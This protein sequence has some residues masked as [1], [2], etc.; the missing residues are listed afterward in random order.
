MDSGLG[1]IG[2][3]IIKQ[4]RRIAI[5]CLRRRSIIATGNLLALMAT[6]HI[7][8]SHFRAEEVGHF[9]FEN[10]WL[11]FLAEWGIFAIPPLLFLNSFLFRR[12]WMIVLSAVPSSILTF[13]ALLCLFLLGAIG[14]FDDTTSLIRQTRTPDGQIISLYDRWDSGGASPGDNQHCRYRIRRSQVFRGVLR[15][16]AKDEDVCRMTA[17]GG[18]FPQELQ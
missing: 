18:P 5:S 2:R 17:G 9:I 12:V 3:K 16:E 11:S 10:E 8:R 7:L 13:S 15:N 6:D 1:S 4:V 14:G